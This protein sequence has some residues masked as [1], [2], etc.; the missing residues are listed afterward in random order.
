MRKEA[1]LTGS[2]RRP[3]AVTFRGRR[4]HGRKATYCEYLGA[5]HTV[6][7]DASVNTL[8]ELSRVLSAAFVFILSIALT[9]FLAGTLVSVQISG[10]GYCCIIRRHLDHEVF[11]LNMG[12]N[13]GN[14]T[15]SR[16]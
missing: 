5:P 9:S 12:Y 2:V 15:G 11:S 13:Y 14:A 10:F 16:D 6:A 1:C 4:L 3:P 8:A 7:Y